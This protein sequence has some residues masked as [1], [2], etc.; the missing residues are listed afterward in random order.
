MPAEALVT[1]Q[2]VARPPCR[3]RPS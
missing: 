2:D 1:G 3:S